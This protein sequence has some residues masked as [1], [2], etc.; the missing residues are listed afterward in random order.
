MLVIGWL[1]LVWEGKKNTE[2][3]L[4]RRQLTVKEEG[5]VDV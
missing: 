5:F 3:K 4:A 1:G 2:K